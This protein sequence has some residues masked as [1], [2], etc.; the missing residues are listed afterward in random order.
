MKKS[1]KTGIFFLMNIMVL[2]GIGFFADYIPKRFL[3]SNF[4]LLL[5]Q[6]SIALPMLIYLIAMGG[7][8][9]KE[10]RH[11]KIKIEEI[12]IIVIFA[13][14]CM[15]VSS[16]LNVVT[17][18]FS[19]NYVAGSIT[20]L[21]NNPFIVNILLIAVLPAVLEE[22]AYRG[23]FFYGLRSYGVFAAAVVSGFLFGVNHMNINQFA[24]AFVL[25]TVF[26]LMDEAS[27]SIYASMIMHFTFNFSTVCLMEM[28]KLKPILEKMQDNPEYEK[29][30]EKSGEIATNLSG[31]STNMKIAMLAGFGIMAVV[32][33]IINFNIFRWYAKRVGRWEHMCE[34]FKNFREGFKKTEEGRIISVPIVLGVLI[35]VFIMFIN[36]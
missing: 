33:V 17:M 23:M 30:M 7:K 16:F 25:G 2:L 24:Y 26:A 13:W 27:D 14:V 15:P 32:A 19:D 3:N 28:V 31:Y 8:P 12:I 29:Y 11:S 6:V 4:S 5:G 9:L 20:E 36:M 22:L 35:S 10:I 34:C 21:S 1:T 18:L